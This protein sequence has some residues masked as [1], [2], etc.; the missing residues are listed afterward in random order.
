MLKLKLQLLWPPD[1]NSQCILK[2]KTC[3]SGIWKRPWHWER[4]RQEEKGTTEEEMVGSHHQLNVP[5]FEQTPRDSG[6]QRSLACCSPWGLQELDISDWRNNYILIF[7]ILFFYFLPLCKFQFYMQLFF[8]LDIL[9][10]LFILETLFK[11]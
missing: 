5:E 7:E 8:S 9:L 2:C 3:F 1:A 4:L 10:F 11:G 6:G